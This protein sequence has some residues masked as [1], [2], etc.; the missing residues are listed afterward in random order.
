MHA[1]LAGILVQDV[2]A[3]PVAQVANPVVVPTIVI[4]ELAS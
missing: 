1:R 3:A 4:G 2:V